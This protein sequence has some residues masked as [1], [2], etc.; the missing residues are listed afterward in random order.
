MKTCPH[1]EAGRA[2]ASQVGDDV[3][4]FRAIEARIRAEA[5]NTDETFVP[6]YTLPSPLENPDGSR[7]ATAAQWMD[8]RR[9]EVIRLYEREMYGS[10][11]P[12]PD[13]L[14]FEVLSVK[15]GAL[16]GIARRRE[17]RITCAMNDGK[18]F[19]FDLLLY[20]PEK[21]KKPVPAFLG[22]N[23]KGNHGC[24]REEDVMM[25]PVGFDDGRF[26][27]VEEARAF[28]GADNML[29][30]RNPAF[31][32]PSSRGIQADRWCFEEVVRRGYAAATVCYEDIFPDNVNGW[33][34]SC[35]ALFEDLRGY[36]GSH[37]KY[38]AIGAWAWG[39]SR[40]LD[41]LETCPEIDAGRVCVHGH[42]RLGKTALWAGATDSRFAMVVSNDSGCGGA[43]L[44]RRVFGENWLVIVNYFPHWFVRSS[45]RFMAAEE[46]M[47]FDQHFLISLMAPRPVAVASATEDL[48]ADPRGEFLAA[49]NAKEVYGLFGSAGLPCD[50][51]P[52]PD[53]FVTGDVSYHLRTGKHN[54][55]PAD[56]AHYLEIADKYLV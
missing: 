18:S 33:E 55:T 26:A 2:F 17:V 38:T 53:V 21:A 37:E 27:D 20:V 3:G 43:A 48:W 34:Y 13:K 1:I 11:P 45:R 49:L 30:V 44:S 46:T 6:E 14:T 5:V 50:K 40:A 47:P 10:K 23:F 19:S 16:G 25:T 56:W 12:R 36:R 32:A 7:I 22:L 41:Y 31:F 35:L 52:G 24:S 28:Y 15:E 54:Q 29:N 8:L 39:L 9:R 42:S 51:M 4:R